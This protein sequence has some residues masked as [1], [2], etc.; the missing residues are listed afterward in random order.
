MACSDLIA[1]R[2]AQAENRLRALA[3][4]NPDLSG[5]HANLGVALRSRG[6]QQEAIA[7]LERAVQLAPQRASLLNTLGVA[8]REAG[9]FAMARNAYERALAIDPGYADAVLNLGILHDLYL[10]SPADALGYFQRYL[11]L[12]PADTQVGKWVAE[13]KKRKPAEQALSAH[14]TP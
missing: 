11:V 13:L 12:A 8:Y 3:R 9:A 5:V 2:V 10:A 7:A 6:Q 1:G 4:T 14:T